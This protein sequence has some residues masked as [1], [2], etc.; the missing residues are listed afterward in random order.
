MNP[1]NSPTYD[2][3]K[4]SANRHK[5]SVTTVTGGGNE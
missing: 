5:T 4:V 1:N 2:L 3:I